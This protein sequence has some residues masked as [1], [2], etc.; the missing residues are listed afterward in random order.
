M[1]YKSG[2][3]FIQ[4]TLQ[5]MSGELTREEEISIWQKYIQKLQNEDC[6]TVDN[7]LGMNYNLDEAWKRLND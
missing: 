5:L 1:S 4:W 6:D 3:E 7:M 2:V